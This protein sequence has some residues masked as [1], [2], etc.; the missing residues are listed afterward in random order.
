[1]NQTW[2]T[3]RQ[4]GFDSR[5]WQRQKVKKNSDSFLS[6]LRGSNPVIGTK[7]QKRK[8]VVTNCTR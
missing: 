6:E 8:G 1:M 7:E 4:P 3:N 5:F 2:P